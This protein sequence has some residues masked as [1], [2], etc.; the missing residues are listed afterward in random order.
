[1]LASALHAIAVG[2][3]LPASVRTVCVDMTEAVPTK[4]SNRGTMQAI[5]L[6]TDVGYFL[7]K[8]ASDLLDG[9]T[10]APSHQESPR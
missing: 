4:L 7:E 3:L 5:G 10:D 1:M 2:N 6:V 8:L 9:A